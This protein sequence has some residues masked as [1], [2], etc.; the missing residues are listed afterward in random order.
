MSITPS[1][2]YS[3]EFFYD[4]TDTILQINF[5]IKQKDRINDEF[6][7]KLGKNAFIKT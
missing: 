2:V 5:R 1:P 6:K 7:V 4:I 3:H